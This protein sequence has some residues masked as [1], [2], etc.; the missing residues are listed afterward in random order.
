MDRVGTAIALLGA[1]RISGSLTQDVASQTEAIHS[2]LPPALGRRR[3]RHAKDLERWFVV[4]DADSAFDGWAYWSIDDVPMSL[5]T[6]FG[7]V[8]YDAGW[9]S[10]VRT[11]KRERVNCLILRDVSGKMTGTFDWLAVAE[12][13]VGGTRGDF[14]V[15]LVTERASSPL[16]NVLQRLK[17]GARY[18]I[19]V[20][21]DKPEVVH[22]VISQATIARLVHRRAPHDADVLRALQATTVEGIGPKGVHSVDARST[23]LDALTIIARYGVS[24]LPIICRKSNSVQGVISCSDLLL[25][26]DVER[27]LCLGLPIYTFV[28]KSREL[29]GLRSRT[30]TTTVSV[31]Q[32]STAWD[33]L[34][35]ICVEKIHHVYVVDALGLP[36]SVVSCGD[37]LRTWF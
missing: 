13:V 32:G 24:S 20:E 14:V 16:G 15:P 22:C 31:T 25:L 36:V 28:R 11:M 30:A 4:D 19:V 17:R 8:K 23:T 21:D 27:M 12:A 6:T 34:Q 35:R 37:L 33:A 26:A 2:A 7:E 18:V 29:Q 10:H 3:L 5:R 1:S 9:R